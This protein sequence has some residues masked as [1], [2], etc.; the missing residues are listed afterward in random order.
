M[1]KKTRDEL[2]PLVVQQQGGEYCVFC[3]RDKKDLMNDGHKPEFCIDVDNNSHD[4]SKK[5]LR[6]MQLACHPCNT[7]K[8]HPSN[9][10]P[11][12]RTATPEMILGKRY[13]SDFRRWVVGLFLPN[14][15]VGF[16]YSYLVGSGAEKVG[17]SPESIKRYLSKMTSDEGMYE[18]DNRFSSE[19]LLVLKPKYKNN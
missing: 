12:T 16:T 11:F 18:W 10:E 4:H 14:E 13:E 1:N 6:E 5:N 19:S 17:C 2:Y 15:N 7:K 8:N 9:T 3:N